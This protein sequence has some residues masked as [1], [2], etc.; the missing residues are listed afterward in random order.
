MQ[1]SFVRKVD[2]Y[3]YK[4][5]V[6]TKKIDGSRL[7]I[8]IMIIA[9]SQVD[10]I[11]GK[12]CFFKETFLLID[13]GINAIFVMFFIFLSNVKVNFNDQEL[14]QKQYTI[15]HVFLTNRQMELVRKK[16][17]AAVTLDSKTRSLQS[18]SRFLPFPIWFIFSIGCKQPY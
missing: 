7:K 4:T 1:L 2:P 14:K 13:M 3:I 5:Y 12:S 16:E 6:G 17:F 8:Y 10:N 9:L 11:D 15:V 18:M